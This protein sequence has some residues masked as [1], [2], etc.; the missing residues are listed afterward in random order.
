MK[1]KSVKALRNFIVP[2][3]FLVSN[4]NGQQDFTNDVEGYLEPYHSIEVSSVE[5][6]IV[7]SIEVRE[8]ETV[9]KGQVLVKL[10]RDVL[11]KSLDVAAQEAKSL[12]NLR[13]AKAE[14][15]LQKKRLEKVQRIFDSGHGRSSEL[16]RA[17]ADLEVA[18]GRVLRAEEEI[19]IKQ[20][21]LAQI[22]AKLASRDVQSPIDGIVIEIHKNPGEAV[23]PNNP[24]L[25]TVVNVNRLKCILNVPRLKASRISEQQPV[26]LLTDQQKSIVGSVQWKSPIV[27]AES[28]TVKI[29]IRIDNSAGRLTSG[30]HCILHSL[31]DLAVSQD[32]HESLSV[33]LQD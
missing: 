18:L 20:K 26:E 15:V 13:A 8:G 27:D 17:K 7:D 30:E 14:L 33:S 29:V 16:E 6:G 12:G 22:K 3:M 5:T 25:V 11:T 21:E 2:F 19:V 32:K 9:K 23:S 24:I 10:D 4:V 28:E 31:G 1:G